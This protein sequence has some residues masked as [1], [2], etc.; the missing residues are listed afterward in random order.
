MWPSFAAG[1]MPV[2]EPHWMASLQQLTEETTT[3]AG[4][5]TINSSG[6]AAHHSSRLPPF[7]TPLAPQLAGSAPVWPPNNTTAAH[8]PPGFAPPSIRPLHHTQVTEPHTLTE[9]WYSQQ[10]AAG[11]LALCSTVEMC[12]WVDSNTRKSWQLSGSFSLKY[13]WTF[14]EVQFLCLFHSVH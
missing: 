4:N 5:N 12:L 10:S 13:V 8:P 6:S 2:E 3:S 7:V 1:V 11:Q 14:L 9:G